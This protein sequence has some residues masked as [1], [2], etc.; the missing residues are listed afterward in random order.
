[1]AEI[2]KAPA[3]RHYMHWLRNVGSTFSK[4][5]TYDE[6]SYLL[7]DELYQELRK[8][9]PCGDRNMREVWLRSDRGT[10]ADLGDMDELIADGEFDSEE[11]AR[12]YWEDMFPEQDYWYLLQTIED[13]D[14]GYRAIFV[15]HEFL[16]EVDPRY[17]KTSLIY[18]IYEFVQWMLHEVKRCIAELEE[19][20][21][22]DNV[23]NNLPAKHRTGTITR[24][25]LFD[26][27][28]EEREDLFQNLSDEDKQAFIACAT[29][30]M[31]EERLHNMT[32]N[33]FYRFCTYGYA[34]NG[35]KGTDRNPM[36]QYFLH[37]DG[38][39]DELREID[40]DSPEAFHKWL[41]ER[42]YHGGHPWE[43][44]R[45][46]NST[47]IALYVSNDK[48]GYYLTLAGSSRVRTIETAK[49]YLALQ[50][51]G[52]PVRLRDA[53]ILVERLQETEKIGIV[54]EGI[55]PVY[56]EGMFPGEHIIAF[57]NLPNE[58]QAE[59]AQH[60]VW[61]SIRKTELL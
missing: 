40:P 35:Y 4:E 8:V 46:G 58:Q 21:Y 5:I 20:T 15:G 28:P 22:N 29:E 57:R 3:I 26:I 6:K 19:G 61:Q 54:P 59:V 42:K 36:E 33:D 11:E 30:A 23:R 52:L 12:N 53:A 45:G 31:P 32:A 24:K 47:H 56:C 49:F 27:F 16:I 44:C 14:T 43:V 41:T 60:C 38:R 37:A 2:I 51:K 18:D 39:D 25:E 48:D 9:K 1:M 13:E 34:A 17:Q 10:L 7:I 55:W 50:R